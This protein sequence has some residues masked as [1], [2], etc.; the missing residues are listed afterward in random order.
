[1]KRILL[2]IDP[3]ATKASIDLLEAARR[4]YASEEL[5]SYGLRLG[6]PNDPAFGILDRVIDPEG[7]H[8]FDLA[9]VADFIAELHREF[10]FSAVL[11]PATVYGRMLAPRAAMRLHVG[12]IADVVDVRRRA[13]RIEMMRPAFGGKMMAGVV[14][15]GPN[16]V[17]M[18]VRPDTF[19]FGGGPAENTVVTRRAPATPGHSGVRLL[20]RRP[21]PVSRDIRDS[22]I[23]V[24]GGGGVRRRFGMLGQLADA[25]GGMV[26]A[27][28]RLVD[29]GV[30]PRHIQVGQSGRT[31]S[32]RLY[33]A[34]GISGSIQ[35]V[36]GLKNAEYVISVNP[37]RHAPICSL[38]DVVVEGDAGEFIRRILERIAAGRSDGDPECEGRKS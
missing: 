34:L 24:S 11:Y 22:D 33:V 28:R 12:L 7:L 29:R 4:M 30:A 10:E 31:V 18:S 17:M 16:P 27:S 9:G 32:P 8:R 1:M 35:H 2:V 6:A 25:L 37:D 23:L 13:G 15:R 20:E 38:S 26:A 14:H 36:A 21:K 5:E 3:D 19:H